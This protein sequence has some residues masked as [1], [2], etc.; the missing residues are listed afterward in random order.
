[1]AD[2]LIN[3]GLAGLTVAVTP[4]ADPE[5]VV[6]I[7]DYVPSPPHECHSAAGGDRCGRLP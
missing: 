5:P 7:K 4:E 6:T 2:D 3:T 1:M